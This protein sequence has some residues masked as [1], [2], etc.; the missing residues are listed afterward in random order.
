GKSRLLQEVTSLGINN[1]LS[2]DFRLLEIDRKADVPPRGP[3]V[4]D[5][6]RD[7]LVG[8]TLHAFEFDNQNVL[9]K[10]VGDSPTRWPL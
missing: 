9:D 4:V 1:K 5:A 6:L 10:N 3:Q 8:E 7:V 2:L